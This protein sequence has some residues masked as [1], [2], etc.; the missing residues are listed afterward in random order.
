MHMPAPVGAR[1]VDQPRAPIYMC[2]PLTSWLF[3]AR[4]GAAQLHPGGWQRFSAAAPGRK[5]LAAAEVE[6]EDEIDEEAA[7][8]RCV[9]LHAQMRDDGACV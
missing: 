4:G 2:T 6:L 9:A 3:G 7:L 8:R 1:G 5:G